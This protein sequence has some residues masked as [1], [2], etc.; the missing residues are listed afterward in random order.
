[1]K[2]KLLKVL[3]MTAT[4]FSVGCTNTSNNQS[5]SLQGFE[6]TTQ[7]Q[8]HELMAGETLVLNVKVY[9]ESGNANV[10]WTSSDESIATVSTEG[11]VTGI[12]AGRVEITC[13]STVDSTIKQSIK[14]IV[15]AK[16]VEEILPESITI[17]SKDNITSIMEDETL[18]LSYVVLPEG[19]PSGVKWSTSNQS[20]ATV[21]NGVVTAISEG[22]VT[23]TATSKTLST[24]SSSINITVTAKPK[25]D[26]EQMDYTSHEDF[27]TLNQEEKVKVKGVVAHISVPSNDKANVYVLNG[28]T[29]Y[30][31]YDISTAK[32]NI[33]VGSSYTIGGYKKVYRGLN[34]IVDI[35]IF[36]KLEEEITYT[37]TDITNMNVK[38]KDAM[39]PYQNSY[40]SADCIISKIPSST[41]SAFSIGITVGENTID[42][43]VDPAVVGQEDF[44]AIQQALATQALNNPLTFKGI[45]SSY[46]Y[47]SSYYFNQ[48]TILKASDLEFTSASETL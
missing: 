9:P 2:H 10:V 48:I 11:I 16:P 5:L 27:L 13:T 40:I 4:L 47:S 7:N 39:L 6:I 15:K 12:K 31:L 35:E 17:S 3:V 14:L 46:G 41:A 29:G 24:V 38:D 44:A 42:L 21:K 34:E 37:V 8:T 32:Y 36:D 30:Y 1:M 22:E 43:R 45:M 20:I 26:W 28:N 33:E 25:L 23:I 18:E 19:A